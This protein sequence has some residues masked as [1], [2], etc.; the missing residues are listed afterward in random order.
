MPEQVTVG[1]FTVLPPA[2]NTP[3]KG[4]FV[5]LFGWTDSQFKYV[6]KYAE[7][8]NQRGF[9]ALVTTAEYQDTHNHMGNA[10]TL[11][12]F[13]ETIPFLREHGLVV[14]ATESESDHRGNPNEGSV[15][16]LFSNGGCIRM[17]QFV[18]S[19]HAQGLALR[20]RAVVLDSAPGHL[21]V[22]GGTA[23][24]TIGLNKWLRP[25][26]SLLVYAYLSG[27]WMMTSEEQWKSHPIETSAVYAVSELHEDGNVFGPRLFI[28]SE[29]DQIVPA[30]D[31]KDWIRFAREKGV[32]VT[33]LVFSDTEHVQHVRKRKDEYW[34][35]VGRFLGSD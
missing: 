7:W 3:A 19:L 26:A 12:L 11:S 1:P 15:L 33:E 9:T 5:L 22:S 13:Q 35:A 23:F 10:T 18:N 30:M 31:T 4:K 24:L 17:R 21:S 32:S 6:A 29:M 28:Y 8:Y 14:S 20:T 34:A 27:V 16:H 2:D 25:V